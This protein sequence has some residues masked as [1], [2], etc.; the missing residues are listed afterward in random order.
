MYVKYAITNID[1]LLI[2][3]LVGIPMRK[4]AVLCIPVRH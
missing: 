1:C 4:F 2:N 3:V